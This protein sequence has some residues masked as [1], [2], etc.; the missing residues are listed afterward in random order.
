MTHQIS[1]TQVENKLLP[2]FRQTISQARSTEDVKKMFG[3]NMQ[4]LFK[5]VSEGVLALRLED[6]ALEP[7]AAGYRIDDRIRELDAFIKVWNDTDLS[8][9][10]DR[11]AQ[12]SLHQYA[13]LAKNPEKTEAKIRR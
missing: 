12:L 4:E 8:R 5:E 7:E 3:Y 11:F 1:F 9:I 13:H 10:V 2:K 6:V